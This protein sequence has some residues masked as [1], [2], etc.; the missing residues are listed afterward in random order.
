[1]CSE[2]IVKKDNRNTYTKTKNRKHASKKH[3]YTFEGDTY[4]VNGKGDGLYTPMLKSIL[5]TLY[6]SRASRRRVLVVRFDLHHKGIHFEDNAHISKFI[7]NLLRKLTRAYNTKALYVWAREV[8]KLNEG[9]HYH[10]ALFIDGN[11]VNTSYRV[12]DIIKATWKY[13]VPTIKKPFYYID[14]QE[15]L[16]DA[17]YRLS[18]LAK[19]FTKG[20]RK[21]T[22]HDF[23]KSQLGRQV[24]CKQHAR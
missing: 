7:K 20:K 4:I 14:S 17:V 18:Y 23:G 9:Q 10:C 3:T 16:E 8:G 1:M 6:T 11:K 19:V 13:T 24:T 2:S 5:E 21:P 15:I 22:V 12:L